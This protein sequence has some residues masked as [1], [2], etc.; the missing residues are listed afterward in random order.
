[1]EA[2]FRKAAEEGTSWISE[3]TAKRPPFPK[4][5]GEAEESTSVLRCPGTKVRQAGSQRGL[6]L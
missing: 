1:M 4:V 3:L 5:K 2:E 6:A